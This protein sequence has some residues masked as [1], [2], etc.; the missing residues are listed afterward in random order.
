[1][2]VPG[3]AFYAGA[4]VWSVKRETGI[5]LDYGRNTLKTAEKYF[6]ER[7]RKWRKDEG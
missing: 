6:L 4:F 5:L 3:C 7:S 1:M 2:L